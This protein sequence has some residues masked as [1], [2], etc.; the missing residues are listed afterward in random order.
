MLTRADLAKY[1]FLNE[2]SDDIKELGISIDDIASPDFSPV[3]ERAKKRLEEA[4]SKGRVSNEFGNENAE[5]LSFP[6]SNLILSLAGEERAQR[7][8]ALA[9]AKRA[10]ELLRQ[11]GPDKLQYIAATTFGWKLKRIETQ[12]GKRVFEFSAGLTDYLRVSAHL[13]DLR[14]KLPNRVLDHGFV[15][16]TREE[17]A[18]LLEE[19]VRMRIVVRT[20]R[21]PR[22]T[23]SL[24]EEKVEQPRGLIFTSLSTPSR[25]ALPRL[26]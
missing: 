25:Y 21:L 14:W 4:L 13:K 19:E 12:L 1:P 17:M 22:R 20:A 6:V 2:A 10:Y 26:P 23:P 3:L 9:E 8:F 5:I 24:L 18:R 11:E 16:L 7:R 15:Y